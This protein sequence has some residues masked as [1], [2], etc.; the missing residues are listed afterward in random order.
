MLLSYQAAQH[1]PEAGQGNSPDT[2]PL[3][4]CQRDHGQ[5]ELGRVPR[6]RFSPWPQAGVSEVLGMA[7][8]L[9]HMEATQGQASLLNP[10]EA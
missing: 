7:L 6:Q 4:G 1:Q 9:E 5:V 8:F 3:H 10:L 2:R